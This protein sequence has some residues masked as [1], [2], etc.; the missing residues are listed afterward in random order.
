MMVNFAR[1]KYNTPWI[2]SVAP[3]LALIGYRSPLQF[4]FGQ[5]RV[6]GGFFVPQMRCLYPSRWNFARREKYS[7]TRWVWEPKKLKS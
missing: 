7:K 5:N 4:K 1:Y 2:P 3:N 6:F